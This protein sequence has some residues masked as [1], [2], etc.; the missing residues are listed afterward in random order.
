MALADYQAAHESLPPGVTNPDGP[1]RNIAEGIHIGWAVSL[2]PYIDEQATLQQIDMSLGVYAEKNAPARAVPIGL[3][4]CPSSDIPPAMVGK[5]VAIS[6]YAGCHNDVESPI[7]DDNHGVLFLDSR[8]RGEDITDG[9]THTIFLGEK[10]SADDDLG[11][12]SGTRATLR[13]TG[14]PLRRTPGDHVAIVRGMPLDDD[15]DAE[16]GNNRPNDDLFVGGFGSWHATVTNFL[17][18]DGA[19]RSVSNDIDPA[20][21]QQLGHRAD[22]KLLDAGP[23]REPW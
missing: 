16:P 6:S 11:W 15:P 21:L 7:D 17:F 14:T 12:M 2:L 9:A 5:D 10:L 19:V 20:I 8:I 18:G 4:R 23:T 22:G 3:L 1:I 13:N